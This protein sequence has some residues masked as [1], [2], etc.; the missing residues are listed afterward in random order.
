MDGLEQ[1]LIGL[2]MDSGFSSSQ[3]FCKVF[4]RQIGMT[5]ASYRRQWQ[6]EE[7]DGTPDNGG[8]T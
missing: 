4:R 6:N 7:K 8:I 2:L 5:P 1:K 3:Y